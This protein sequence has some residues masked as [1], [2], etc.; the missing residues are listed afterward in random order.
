[1]VA[2]SLIASARQSRSPC[3][4]RCPRWACRTGRALAHPAP[5]SPRGRGVGG[6]WAHCVRRD[7]RSPASM[8]RWRNGASVNFTRAGCPGTSPVTS[9]LWSG[10]SPAR[11]AGCA[12]PTARRLH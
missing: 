7:S 12:R 4:P 5:L 6:E 11:G 3:S 9:R 10:P 2:F 1:M 8:C